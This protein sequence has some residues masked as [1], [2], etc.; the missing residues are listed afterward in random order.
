MQL[1]FKSSTSKN[2][3]KFYDALVSNDIT[4]SMLWHEICDV[5]KIEEMMLSLPAEEQ[6]KNYELKDLSLEENELLDGFG[7]TF[8]DSRM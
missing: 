6:S 5:I 4:G 1:G 7:T 3:Q 8:I 2:I